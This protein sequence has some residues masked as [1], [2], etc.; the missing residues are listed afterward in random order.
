VELGT[1]LTVK[2]SLEGTGNI[3]NA[4]LPR[5]KAPANVRVYDPTNNDKPAIKA[6]RLGGRRTQEYLVAPQSTGTFTLPAL[7]FEYFDP[8]AGE[9]RHAETDPLRIA[10]VPGEGNADLAQP[11]SGGVKNVLSGG[12]LGPLVRRASLETGE[13]PLWTKRWFWPAV[14]S[15]P[16]AWLALALTSAWVRLRRVKLERPDDRRKRKAKDAAARLRKAEKLKQGTAS[17]F[18][19]EVERALGELLE[20][21]LKLESPFTGMTRE[22]L[23]Q[24]MGALD[25]APSRQSLVL[26]V[27]EHCDQG[28][29]APGENV[30]HRDELLRMAAAAM[31]G[32]E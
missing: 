7:R 8:L 3:R 17:D 18:Y 21:R 22:V 27:L 13:G 5:L 15:P 6:G 14:A 25:V 26:R 4:E 30:A 23:S 10:V 9:Y 24:K 28:R 20:A 32:W 12:G 16:F 31:E 19:G 29:F 2:V 1:P 11:P